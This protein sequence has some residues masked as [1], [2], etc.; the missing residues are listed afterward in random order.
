ME[1]NFSDFVEERRGKDGFANPAKVR[2]DIYRYFDTKIRKNNFY[3]KQEK[4]WIKNK[5]NILSRN[6][7]FIGDRTFTRIQNFHRQETIEELDM[8]PTN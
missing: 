8:Q 1:R 7:T 4:Q 2:D 6:G 3:T 5:V